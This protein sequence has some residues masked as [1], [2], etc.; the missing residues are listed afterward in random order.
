MEACR[1]D[2]AYR[3]EE[4]RAR[5]CV[6]WGG[7]GDAHRGPFNQSRFSLGQGCAQ[8]STLSFDINKYPLQSQAK[9]PPPAHHHQNNALSS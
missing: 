8:I 2:D 9:Q 1:M 5:R 4:W 3:G 6:W 7:T